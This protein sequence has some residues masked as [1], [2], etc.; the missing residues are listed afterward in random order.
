MAG[1]WCTI[2]LSF[3]HINTCHTHKV[4]RLTL[5]PQGHDEKDKLDLQLNVFEPLSS[6][7]PRTVSMVRKFI[8]TLLKGEVVRER[9]RRRGRIGPAEKVKG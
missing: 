3:T 2:R 1:T 7:L 8:L 4:S 9:P 5:G 6:S